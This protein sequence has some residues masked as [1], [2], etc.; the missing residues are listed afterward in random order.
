MLGVEPDWILCGNGSDDIL[1]IVTRAFVGHGQLLRLPYPS[2][3]LY[4]T[5]AQ[6]QGAGSEEVHF[7]ADWSLPD[8]FAAAADD[9]RLVFLPNPN[10]PSGTVVAAGADRWNSPSGCPARCWSTRPMPISP[11]RTAWTWW[12]RTRRSWSRGR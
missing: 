11:R 6:I 7:S 2:Y 5:L 8:R 1:T 9:L 12:R 4:E 3:I 10:S